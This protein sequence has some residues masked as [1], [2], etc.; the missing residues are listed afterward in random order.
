MKK[1]TNYSQGTNEN[2]GDVCLRQT[3]IGLNA[4]DIKLNKIKEK[5]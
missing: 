1:Q 5:K 2:D 3:D 4:P